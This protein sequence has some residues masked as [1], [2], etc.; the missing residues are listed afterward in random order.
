[1]PHSSARVAVFLSLAL[2]SAP[3][4]AQDDPKVSTAPGGVIDPLG[5]R[6]AYVCTVGDSASIDFRFAG[7]EDGQHRIEQTLSDGRSVGLSRYP[8]Q[9]AT[10]TLFRERVAAD[11]AVKFRRLNGSLR[12]LHELRPD[13]KLSAEYAEASLDGARDAYEWRYEVTAGRPQASFAPSGLGEVVAIPIRERRWRYVDAAGAP[14]PLAD[15]TAGFERREDATITFSPDLGVVLRW[16]R[17]D[18]T[19]VLEACSLSVYKKP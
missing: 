8:W 12:Q 10:A 18:Q 1:M 7:F 16:E 6:G 3:A 9:L 11:G 4:S 19:A 2:A 17:R 14:L 13:H 15:A 5:A